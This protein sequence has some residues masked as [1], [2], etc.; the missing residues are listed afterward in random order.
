MGNSKNSNHSKKIV[1]K[2]VN[3]LSVNPTKWSNT[4][5]QF[6]GKKNG[7]KAINYF[8]NK[9]HRRCFIGF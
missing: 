4:F 7:L 2:I 5:K 1:S 8:R 6:V 9:L 3:L